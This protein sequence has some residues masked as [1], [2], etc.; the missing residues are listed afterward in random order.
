MLLTH[1]RREA[2]TTP[3]GTLIPLSEQDRTRW[4]Q[5]EIGAGL[6]LV[7]DAVSAGVV[8]LYQVQAA[9][10]AVHAE[11]PNTAETDWRQI[12]A[13]YELL[14][15]IT[16]NPVFTLNRAVAVGML[17]GPEAG[18]A[19]LAEAEGDRRLAGSHRVASVRGHLLE[20]AG[21]T[22]GAAAAYELAARLTTS[23]PE[24]QYLSRKAA[25][26]GSGK[27][28]R[29]AAAASGSGERQRRAASGRKPQ[30]RPGEGQAIGRR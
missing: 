5:A 30:A 3:D 4:H 19:V 17:R 28:Q 16:P 27:P 21:D 26:S 25:A 12:T 29:R 13:L 20:L 18:L 10:A 24:R 22:A 15:H 1:A 2:R 23:M 8:G 7:T 14:E 11:A 9:I 6:G